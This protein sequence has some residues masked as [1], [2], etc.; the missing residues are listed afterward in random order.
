MGGGGNEEK[1]RNVVNG[2]VQDHKFR[3]PLRGKGNRGG[4][5]EQ[6]SYDGIPSNHRSSKR[7]ARGRLLER[8]MISFHWFFFSFFSP[9]AAVEL[10]TE[11]MCSTCCGPHVDG[12]HSSR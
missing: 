10:F 4:K 7:P 1:K 2:R 5:N 6:S 3:I 8:I 9:F 11:L 12:A